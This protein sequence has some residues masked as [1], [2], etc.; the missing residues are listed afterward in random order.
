MTDEK[1]TSDSGLK[2]P[3]PDADANS[4]A[5]QVAAK[6][7]E[8]SMVGNIGELTVMADLAKKSPLRG[9]GQ[10]LKGLDLAS[11]YAKQYAALGE[12]IERLGK[13]PSLDLNF[14][15]PSIDPILTKPLPPI[16]R[17]EV[18][19]L[20]QVHAELVGLAKLISETSKQTT[21]NVELTR[22]NLTALQAMLAEMQASR[23]SAGNWNAALIALT[24]ALFVAAGVAAVA[25]YPQFINEMTSLWHWLYG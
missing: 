1:P 4:A 21:A 14:K 12:S 20:R 3:K 10:L 17:A 19:L 24:V 7:L 16:Q 25:V 2:G 11:T 18:G 9:V 8:K 15:M 13:M 6:D 5:D 23:K 22:A